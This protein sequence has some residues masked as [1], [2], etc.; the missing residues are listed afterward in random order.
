MALTRCF[1]HRLLASTLGIV[2]R[3]GDLIR[4]ITVSGKLNTIDK[5]SNRCDVCP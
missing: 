2:D 3:A 4:D 1:I 5:V